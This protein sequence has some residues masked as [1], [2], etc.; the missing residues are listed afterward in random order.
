MLNKKK[1][2]ILL[3]VKHLAIVG[4]GISGLSSAYILSQKY[5]ISLFEAASKLGGHTN[6]VTLKNGMA[7]DTGFIVFNEKNY[8]NFCKFIQKLNVDSIESNMSFAYFNES[9]NYHYSSDF[10]YGIFSTKRNL[11]SPSFYR[12]LYEITR[13]NRL[14]TEASTSLNSDITIHEFLVQNGFSKKLI[15]EYVI[16][17]GAA[18]WS[19]SQKDTYEF[20]AKTFLSFWNNHHLLQLFNRPKW[21]TIKGGSDTY[22]R[23]VI[24][25]I[26]LNYVTNHPIQRI[27]RNKNHVILYGPNGAERFDGVVIATHADQALTMLAT[28]SE[29]EQT[30]L[31]QWGYSQNQTILHQSKSLVPKNRSGWASWIYTRHND[32]RMT[33]TYWMN[34]LQGLS[35]QADYFVTLNSQQSIPK[36]EVLYETN[37]EHPMMTKASIATQTDLDSLNGYLNTYFCGSYFG[38]GFHEDGISAAVNVGKHLECQF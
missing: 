38:N 14:G 1:F 20:P 16:P 19:T 28:P 22:I 25:Q 36:N 26:N 29:Q 12:F 8:P 30:L 18:I 11:F 13:F 27:E 7:I 17:M 9:S 6:T 23:A 34:R 35:S 21:R 5:K 37:Y 10:P 32:D 15:N 31:G 3:L 33:A 4:S 24:D 2:Y